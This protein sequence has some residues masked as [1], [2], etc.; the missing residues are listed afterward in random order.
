MKNKNQYYEGFNG[1]EE[2]IDFLKHGILN[3]Y[4]LNINHNTK[5]I[6]NE[7]KIIKIN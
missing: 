7:N 2:K 4:G 5:E 3:D 6:Y 1:S